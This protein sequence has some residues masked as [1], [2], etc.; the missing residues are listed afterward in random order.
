MSYRT[1]IG[2]ILLAA[3]SSVS[4][5]AADELLLVDEFNGT[6]NVDTTV[7]RLPFGTEGNFVGRTQYRGDPN[8]DIPQQ[9]GGNAEIHFNTYSPIDPGNA[10]LG[11]DLLSKRN[12]GRGGGVRF[13]S[14]MR[15]KPGAPG[16]LVGGF[17]TFDVTRDTPPGSNTQVRDEIDFEILSN[18]TVGAATQDISTNYWNEGPFTGPNSGGDFQFHDVA[19]LDLTEFQ[20]YR[21]DWTPQSIK[22]YVNDNLVRTSTTDVPDDPMKLHFNLWAPDSD[23]S[24]AFNAALQPEAN[25]ANDQ[26]YTLQVDRVEVNRFNTTK[27][28]NLLSNFSFE[29]PAEDPAPIQNFPATT[30]DQWLS[31]GNV[32]VEF[33]DVS[34]TD[35]TVPDTAP[36]GISMLKMFGPF[37]GSSDAS[38]VLQNVVAS[39][40]QEFEASVEAL[41]TAGD[42]IAGTNNFTTVSLSFLDASGNVLTEQ[43]ADPGNFRNSNGQEFPLLDGR[44]PN[45][46]EDE[47]VEGTVNGVAPAGTAFARLSVLFIQVIDAAG[48][49]D[50]GAA[51]FDNAQLVLL[52]PDE[53]AGVTGD[54]NG[55]GVVDAADYT[56]WRNALGTATALANDPIGGTVGEA[57]FLQWRSNYGTVA[58]SAA[59]TAAVPEPSMILLTAMGLFAGCVARRRTH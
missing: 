15:L 45:I 31:F 10:F 33:D 29:I 12:F 58:G 59:S 53:V 23:F 16:G 5:L 34:G 39:E 28:D 43:F 17:F 11:T 41:T 8:T 36:E 4:A 47:F 7:W 42:S 21:I 25:I 52:T 6:G 50:G 22:W 26:Q 18:Q 56:T 19:G 51:W 38:G 9:V 27:S 1:F 46:V 40:G 35:P 57:Q 2:T 14:R 49:P 20:D 44:S 32:F 3:V 48:G 37:T 54:Y 13:E 55:D 30:T 24:S